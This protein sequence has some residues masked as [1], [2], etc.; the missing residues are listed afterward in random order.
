M[1]DINRLM[2]ELQKAKAIICDLR[3]YP[4]GNHQLISHLLKTNDTAQWMWIPLIVYPDYEQV[5]YEKVGWSMIPL[6]PT[7][8]A[9]IVFITDSRAISYAE[10]YLGYIEGNK[11]A[12]I[13]GQPTAGTNGNINP[14]TL[15]GGYFLTWTGMRVVKLDGSQHHG[16]GIIPNVPMERTINGVKAGRD[17]FLE[18][19][20]EIARR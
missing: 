11:L 20:L 12:T 6:K 16:V 2:P 15:P 8:S 1:E 17:E 7:L 4:N 19:A 14:F 18:K 13:V 3:G 10:S 9:K 5:T